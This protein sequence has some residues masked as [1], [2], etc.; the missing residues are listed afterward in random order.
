[1]ADVVFDRAERAEMA[2][3]HDLSPYTRI[4]KDQVLGVLDALV[5]YTARLSP[6]DAPLE[7]EQLSHDRELIAAHGALVR[8]LREIGSQEWAGVPDRNGQVTDTASVF[9]V[10]EQEQLRLHKYLKYVR[11]ITRRELG[12][13]FELLARYSALARRYQFRTVN[14]SVSSLEVVGYNRCV[15]AH[16]A[17]VEFGEAPFT[18]EEFAED[19]HRSV[20]SAQALT[21]GTSKPWWRFW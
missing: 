19:L 20:L 12:H 4:T 10:E 21:R 9:D 8:Y 17:M 14:G 18:H 7:V 15:H 3:S 13:L 6:D 2:R 1:M 11:G 5:N 16:N